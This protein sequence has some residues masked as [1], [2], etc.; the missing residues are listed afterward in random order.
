MYMKISTTSLLPSLFF[1]I[2]STNVQQE[3]GNQHLLLKV[4]KLSMSKKENPALVTFLPSRDTKSSFAINTS[5]HLVSGDNP[6]VKVEICG[7]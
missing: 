4:F 2:G 5:K 7:S 1:C 3:I 6:P